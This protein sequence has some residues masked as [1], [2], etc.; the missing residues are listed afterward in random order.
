[1]RRSTD[2]R[3][4]NTLGKVARAQFHYA[5]ATHYLRA[6]QIDPAYPMSEITGSALRG[7]RLEDS[8]PRGAQL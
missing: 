5:D 1:V 8:M 2:A 3:P 6:M 7:R 4:P